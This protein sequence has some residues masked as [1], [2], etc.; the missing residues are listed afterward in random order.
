MH[1]IIIIYDKIWRCYVSS[2]Y[3][4]QQNSK[5]LKI[6]GVVHDL[7]YWTED[8]HKLI[9]LSCSPGSMHHDW[10]CGIDDRGELPFWPDTNESFVFLST[11]TWLL[12]ERL[13]I[14]QFLVL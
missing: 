8:A 9:R 1:L 14:E 6:F 10:I 7:K 11:S 13:S 12:T 4:Q 5:E 3:E 2:K